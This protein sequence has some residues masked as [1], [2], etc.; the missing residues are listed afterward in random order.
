MAI[1]KKSTRILSAL[2]SKYKLL[3]PI[4]CSIVF[5]ILL[6]SLPTTSSGLA[7][8]QV[9]SPTNVSPSTKSTE[10]PVRSTLPA[11]TSIRDDLAIRRRLRDTYARIEGL[12]SVTVKVGAGVVTLKG[13]VLSLQARE[14]AEA[15]AHQVEGVA[16]VNDEI[17]V[18]RD[19][20]RRLAPTVKRINKRFT[21][22]ISYLPLLLV[23]IAIFSTSLGLAALMGRW[24]GAYRR[25]T[26][27]QFMQELLS[28]LVRAVILILGAVI[29]LDILD[30]TTFVSTIL[31]AAGVVGLALGFGFRDIVENYI[32]SILLSLRQPFAPYDHVLIEG[33]EGRVV[34]LT[35]RSTIL[36][37]VSG[38]S[39]R[40]PNAIVFKSIILNYSRNPKRR[41]SF[42]IPLDLNIDLYKARSAVT[43]MLNV[44]NGVLQ[45]PSPVVLIESLNNSNAILRIHCWVDQQQ[46]DCDK[47]RSESIRLVKKALDKLA[48]TTSVKEHIPSSKTNGLG[49]AMDISRDTHIEQEI[50]KARVKEDKENLLETEVRR[51]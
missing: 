10:P 25:L 51:E 14:Q 19:L 22:F 29:A 39:V 32:A 42:D 15:L 36:M 30:A 4:R 50:I 46:V 24:R 47:V 21:D 3:Q 38:E 27:N 5:C 45:D 17:T 12:E 49:V 41:F 13:E 11:T 18:A 16:S 1:L 23:S 26:G 28:Q 7:W 43:D 34:R 8:A 2:A 31:G 33:R 40:I 6:S 9:L 44:M 20:K 35:L 37:A 48:A